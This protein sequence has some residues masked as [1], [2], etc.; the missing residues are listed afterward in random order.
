[1]TTD[2]NTIVAVAGG[3]TFTV[4]TD[5]GGCT[6]EV[7]TTTIAG[8]PFDSSP[9]TLVGAGAHPGQS[10]STNPKSGFAVITVT[11]KTSGVSSAPQSLTLIAAQG[12]P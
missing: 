4:K 1:M 10:I 2:I 8:T 6:N 5:A 3:I 12:A 11:G 7:F 9:I